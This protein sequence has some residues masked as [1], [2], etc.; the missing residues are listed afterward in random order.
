MVVGSAIRSLRDRKSALVISPTG[1]GKTVMG[2]I[3]LPQ[4]GTDLRNIL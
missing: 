3:F 2:S 1:T 4:L